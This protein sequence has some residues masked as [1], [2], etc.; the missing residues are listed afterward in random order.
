MAVA[1][2]VRARRPV[3]AVDV[4]VVV[5]LIMVASLGFGPTFGGRSY[6]LVAGIG[7]L[8]GLAIAWVGAVRRA[9]AIGVAAVT[10]LAYF[11]FGGAVALRQTTVA[12]IGP[13]FVTLRSLALDAV[14][15]WKDLLTVVP[16]AAAFPDVMIV[17]FLSCLVVAVLA[18]SLALR[19]RRPGWALL[20]LAALTVGTILLGTAQVAWPIGQGIAFGVVGLGWHAWRRASTRAELLRGSS[21]EL[22][23]TDGRRTARAMRTRRIRNAAVLLA[24]A[25]TLTAAAAPAL[26][27]NGQRHVLRDTIVPPL[28]L[29][30]YASPLVGFRRYVKDMK[31]DVLFTV[32]GL[33]S[34]ARIRLAT[35]DAYTGTVI[36]VAGGSPGSPAGSGS[37]ARVAAGAVP[38]T[39]APP[40]ETAVLNVLPGSVAAGRR[41][42][43]GRHVRGSAL[44][45]TPGEPV[46]QCRHGND[47]LHGGS[48]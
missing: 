7:T 29:R 5:V 18:G 48:A 14:T 41:S 9:S 36:D 20:P 2:S 43:T 11:L 8:T 38:G 4:V 33:P 13:T 37:F 46:P 19:A 28:D 31:K 10:V 26:E 21:A 47:A 44:C 42:A 34:G 32:T 35:M 40:G 30:E 25:G 45:G 22:R 3:A 39:S 27:P 15:S 12:G 23:D 24:I 1:P 6:L 16:P 17:P